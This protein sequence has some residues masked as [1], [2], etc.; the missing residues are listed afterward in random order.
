MKHS[1]A[2]I[3]KKK[4]KF[5]IKRNI[6]CVNRKE[7]N[8]KIHRVFWLSVIKMAPLELD[9]LQYFYAHIKVQLDCLVWGKTPSVCILEIICIIDFQTSLKETGI[10]HLNCDRQNVW[11]CYFIKII[12][13]ALWIPSSSS[14]PD[15]F[16]FFHFFCGW[17]LDPL[18]LRQPRQISEESEIEERDTPKGGIW[19]EE[20]RA[21]QEIRQRHIHDMHSKSS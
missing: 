9:K 7:A 18:E 4:K 16:F 5:G 19:R 14:G 20:Q 17:D 10:Y 6:G 12:V 13:M 2:F 8:T 11:P 1:K 3:K 21:L 15:F